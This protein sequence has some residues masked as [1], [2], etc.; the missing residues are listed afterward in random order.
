MQDIHGRFQGSTLRLATLQPG[1]PGLFVQTLR[2]L[3]ATRTVTR[4]S[5][6]LGSSWNSR[7]A[8]CKRLN[9]ATFSEDQP[10]QVPA[11]SVRRASCQESVGKQQAVESIG[12]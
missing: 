10:S 5:D 9:Q 11:E 2:V 6:Q 7:G 4:E 1:L 8:M 3:I 12:Q